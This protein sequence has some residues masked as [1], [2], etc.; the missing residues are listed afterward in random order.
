VLFARYAVA[1]SLLCLSFDAVAARKTQSWQERM[2]AAERAYDN[3]KY[4]DAITKLSALLDDEHFQDSASRQKARLLLAFSYY[5][6]QK[7]ADAARELERLFRENVD[8]PLDRDSTHPDVLRFYDRERAKYVAPT[9]P[10]SAPASQPAETKV[11]TVAPPASAP[12]AAP[13]ATAVQK[14]EVETIGDRHKWVRIFPGGVGHFLNHDFGAGAAFLSLEAACVGTNIAF[15][16]MREQLRL[17]DRTF[18]AGSP[19]M[20]YQIVMDVAAL[21]AITLAVVEIIDA[22]VGSPAR[23]RAS[24]ARSLEASL[25]PLGSYRFAFGL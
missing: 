5:I 15:A 19:Q 24:L 2:A 1:L 7:E 9:V 25:G 12:Q 22:F 13:D 3:Y 8:Y 6:S 16:V 14:P 20:T 23:G 11:I 4:K 17:R 21:A 10:T 18:P